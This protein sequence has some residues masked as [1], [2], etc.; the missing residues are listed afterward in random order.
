M[1]VDRHTV[2]V[3]MG[4]QNIDTDYTISMVTDIDTD[5]YGTWIQRPNGY[6]SGY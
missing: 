5:M 2:W 3:Q 1:D 4:T 6:R